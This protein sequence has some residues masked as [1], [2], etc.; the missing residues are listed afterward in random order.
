[1]SRQNHL[2]VVD[3]N[4][5]FEADRLTTPVTPKTVAECIHACIGELRKIMKEGQVALDAGWLIL[6]EYQAK[7]PSK[8]PSVGSEFLKWVYR[9][10]ADPQR[11]QLVAISAKGNSATQFEEFPIH[12]GLAKFDAN[13]RKFVAV[14]IAHPQHP[15]ILQATDAKW[16]GWRQALLECGVTVSFLCSDMDAKYAKKAKK[17]KKRRGVVDG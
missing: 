16:W 7:L 14:A 3:T 12:S 5:L 2:R 13:D 1:M 15:D 4:V 11:C 6:K 9:Y 17:T 10:N 8:Q